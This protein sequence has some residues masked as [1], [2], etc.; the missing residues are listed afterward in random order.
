MAEHTTTGP[1]EYAIKEPEAALTLEDLT[2]ATRRIKRV[3]P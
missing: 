3:N 1:N 2:K